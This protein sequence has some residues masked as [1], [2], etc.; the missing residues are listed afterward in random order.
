M[1]R[2][3]GN[4]AG[5]ADPG[6]VLTQKGALLGASAANTP[7]EVP[8]GADGEVLVFDSSTPTGTRTQA[9]ASMTAGDKAAVRLAKHALGM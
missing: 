7:V 4:I 2:D 8:P 5:V 9:L 3:Q 1:A 6:P